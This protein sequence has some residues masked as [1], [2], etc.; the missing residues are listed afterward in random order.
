MLRLLAF[1]GEDRYG[2][3]G[4]TA[5][6]EGEAARDATHRNAERGRPM[7]NSEATGGPDLVVT[8]DGR[9]S[10]RHAADGAITI[11][12]NQPPSDL[13]IAHPAV[14]GAHL[15]LIP[16]KQQ[17]CLV[18]YESL[19]GVYI[20]GARLRGSVAIA[21]GMTVHLANPKGVAVT[22]GYVHPE[23]ITAP[24]PSY[25]PRTTT[26]ATEP[27]A[28]R[29]ELATAELRDV[30][31]DVTLA[32]AVGRPGASRAMLSLLKR[33]GHLRTEFTA[34]AADDDLREARGFLIC[35][36]AMYNALVIRMSACA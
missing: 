26:P 23:D 28:T 1:K 22:F 4:A 3:T 2:L 9:T 32:P 33:L 14:S 12:R 21:D 16:D 13:S 36:E 5:S 19:N 34:L 30:I 25:P 20:G 24:A 35:V 27:P 10:I 6:P 18:D 15:R 7:Q 29:Y 17:W 31:K 11:G 8:I